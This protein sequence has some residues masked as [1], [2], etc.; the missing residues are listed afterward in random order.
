[1][2]LFIPTNHSPYMR[3]K[4]IILLAI[5][6]AA[7]MN[8]FSQTQGAVNDT[9][10]NPPV[11]YTSMPRSYEIADIK[12]TGADNYD[13]YLVIG[14]AGLNV[15]DVVE[16]P[17]ND[18]TNAIKRLMRQGLFAQAQIKVLKTAGNKA[19]LELAVRT[20]PSIS[21]INYL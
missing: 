3:K 1:M 21:S 12:V 8:A 5:I 6:S 16:I 18:I 15:G 20:Q 13:D 9:I 19:W 17:G 2:T 10:Y 14:Y 4:L 11:L 7:T